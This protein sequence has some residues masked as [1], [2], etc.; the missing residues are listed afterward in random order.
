MVGGPVVFFLIAW[1]GLRAIVGPLPRPNPVQE[2]REG[3]VRPGM[4]VREVES[5]VGTPKSITDRPDGGF[6]YRYQRSAWDSARGTML[7]EDAYIDF[8]PSD[9]VTAVTFDAR[10]PEVSK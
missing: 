6:T 3:A 8:S 1:F 10:V 5:S 7:E 9:S 2:L 4:S